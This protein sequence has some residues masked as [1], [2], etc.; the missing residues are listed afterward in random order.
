MRAE[1]LDRMQH[2]GIVAREEAIDRDRLMA[3]DECFLTN[4]VIGIWPVNAIENIPF[5]V[6]TITRTLVTELG[7]GPA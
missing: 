4:A 3:A 1:L 5:T 2:L 7:A 6:G